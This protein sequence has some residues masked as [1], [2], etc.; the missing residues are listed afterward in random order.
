MLVYRAH[1]STSLSLVNL[2]LSLCHLVKL[3]IDFEDLLLD[4]LLV[5][6]VLLV[7]LIEPAVL[8]GFFIFE[9]LKRLLLL[10]HRVDHRK[11]LFF[12]FIEY[13]EECRRF[14]KG[15]LVSVEVVG[16]CNQILRHQLVKPSFP[17]G[18]GHV[19]FHPVVL[20]LIGLRHIAFILFLVT[21]VGSIV[22]I[23]QLETYRSMDL[24]IMLEQYIF[25]V[26]ERT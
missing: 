22:F 17:K 24:F 16:Y 20:S 2:L 11:V 21:R 14:I 4:F 25:V 18:L 8:Y 9:L 13:L 6:V 10:L 26:L 5:V 1:S 23:N 15:E 3:R 19:L 12:E 7:L